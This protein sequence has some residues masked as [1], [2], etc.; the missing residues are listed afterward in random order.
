[1][2]RLPSGSLAMTIKIDSMETQ[3]ACKKFSIFSL[4]L[5][6]CEFGA[7]QNQVS[8]TCACVAKIIQDKP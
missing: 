2:P 1:M 4:F 7:R 3:G 8:R 6:F 5:W